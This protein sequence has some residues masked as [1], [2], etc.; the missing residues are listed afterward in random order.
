MCG[1][2][3]TLNGSLIR[4]KGCYVS[5]RH[6]SLVS[7]ITKLLVSAGCRDVV[8]EP[9]FLPTAGV[10][11]PPGSNTA[12]NANAD[13]SARSIWNPLE[14]AFLDIRVYH[15]QAPSNR[16]LKN[17]K[18]IPRMYSHHEVQKKCVYNARIL[19]VERG[20]FTPLFVSTYYGGMGEDAKTLFKRV[21]AK[22]ANKTGQKYSE[23]ITFIRKRLRFNLQNKTVIALRGYRGKPSSSSSTDISHLEL[24]IEPKP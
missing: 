6:N 11:L 10:T 3:N 15:A 22:M 4:K 14:K 19:E 7:L 1:E 13:V 9:L 8:T 23:T 17:L 24:N 12:D 18:T 5:M 21:T 16:N 20:V 2:I